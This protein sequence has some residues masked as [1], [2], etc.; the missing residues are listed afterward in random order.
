MNWNKPPIS[1]MILACLYLAV[2]TIA[3]VYNFPQLLASRPDTIWVELTELLAI[4]CGA[5]MLRGYNW[6]RWLA[7]AWIVAHVILSAFHAFHGF[8]IHG[9]FCAVIIWLLFRPP[10]ARF[11]RGVADAS[12]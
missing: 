3:F 5:G 7:V 4:V 12:L 2:G 9:V 6:A 1:V 10:A 11:F 8:A